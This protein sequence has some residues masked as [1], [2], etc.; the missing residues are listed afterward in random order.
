MRTIAVGLVVVAFAN[1][2]AWGGTVSFTPDKHEIYPVHLGGPDS[3]IVNFDLAIA[4]LDELSGGQFDGMDAVVGS[5]DGLL[6]TNFVF[7]AEASAA[8]FSVF[9]GMDVPGPGK[10]ESDIKFGFFAAAGTQSLVFPLGTITVD[11]SGL[12]VGTYQVMIDQ[13]FDQQS[14]AALGLP[15]E[16]LFGV[17]TINI[18]PEPATM[19]LLGL[20]SLA[21][22][23]RRRKG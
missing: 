16:G 12:G 7:S 18:V 17:G 10:Y 6:V 3:S 20:A 22:I 23:R 2:Y 13:D 21:L 15:T 19:T 9:C 14:F 1:A 4:T 11:T 5:N 8:C